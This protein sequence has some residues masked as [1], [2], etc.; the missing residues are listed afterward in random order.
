M[1]YTYNVIMIY[2]C[3]NIITLIIRVLKIK[4]L[5]TLLKRLT[6]QSLYLKKLWKRVIAISHLITHRC[7]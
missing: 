5:S 1:L 6:S 7:Q 4:L 3:D 2:N